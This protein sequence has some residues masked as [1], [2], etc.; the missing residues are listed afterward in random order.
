MRILARRRRAALLLGC[1]SVGLLGLTGC[2]EDALERDF[3]NEKG[4]YEGPAGTPLTQEQ[5]NELNKRAYL[6]SN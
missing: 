3:I 5:Q 4:V 6:Q 2:K 1:L